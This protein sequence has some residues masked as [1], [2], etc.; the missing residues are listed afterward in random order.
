MTFNFLVDLFTTTFIVCD[1]DETDE[2][3]DEDETDDDANNQDE[4][5]N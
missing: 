3:D 2:D 1:E 5:G 4:T